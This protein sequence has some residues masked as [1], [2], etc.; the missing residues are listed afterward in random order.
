MENFKK[1]LLRQLVVLIAGTFIACG[2]F[3]FSQ[4]FVGELQAP[5]NLQ[6]FILGFQ[7]ILFA[8]LCCTMVFFMIRICAVINKPEDLKKLYI[9]ETDE[10]TLFIRQ[11]AGSTG[12]NIITY[13]LIVAAVVAGSVNYT[14][15]LSLLGACFFVAIIRGSL[16]LYY[17]NKF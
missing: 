3:I 16:K 6:D 7:T 13:G 4:N 15:F 2:A 12:M 5:R 1:K 10:R 11:K 17:R 8:F 14:V 9:S